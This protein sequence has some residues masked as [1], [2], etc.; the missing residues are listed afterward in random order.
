MD[1]ENKNG[2]VLISYAIDSLDAEG[3][4][5]TYKGKKKIHTFKESSTFRVLS[6]WDI[7]VRSFKN[8][9]YKLI[10]RKV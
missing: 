6:P 8:W 10:H 5:V 2:M 1:I 3:G 4:K 9:F 7:L